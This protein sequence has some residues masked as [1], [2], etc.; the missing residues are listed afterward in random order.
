MERVA[1]L[2]QGCRTPAALSVST[3]ALK[4][5]QDMLPKK[6]KDSREMDHF[7]EEGCSDSVPVDR[8]TSRKDDEQHDE[9]QRW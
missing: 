3:T 5:Q 2:L 6:L 4:D 1:P 9:Q 7:T 8:K